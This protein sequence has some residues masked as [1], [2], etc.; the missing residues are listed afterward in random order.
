[1]KTPSFYADQDPERRYDCTSLLGQ[2]G[3]GKEWEMF[4]YD[5]PAY[6]FWNGVAKALYRRGWSDKEIKTWLQ[7]KDSRHA[8][9]EGSVL[10]AIEAM[11]A[12]LAWNAVKV[13]S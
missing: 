2:L 9:D 1:M 13:E 7:S 12:L 5:R 8:L 4:S 11:A 6:T 10:E 3:S